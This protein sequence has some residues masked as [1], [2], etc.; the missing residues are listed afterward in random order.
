MRI[1]SAVCLSCC[2]GGAAVAGELTDQSAPA[3][4]PR[5]VR[6]EE[7]WRLGG[8]SDGVMF[9]LMIE[10]LSDADGNVYLLD[11][12]LNQVTVVA[13]DG[14]VRGTLFR[15]GDGPGEVRTPQDMMFLPDGSLAAA[16]QF[17]GKL[18]A[19][20]AD[21]TPAATVTL[22]RADAGGY[23]VMAS[24]QSR[25]GVMLVGA[26][27]QAPVD[28]GQSRLSYLATIG[29]DGAERVRYCEHLTI[30]DFEKAHFVEREMLA[31]FLGAHGLAP[32]GRVYAVPDRNAY[33]IDVYAPDGTARGSF[34]RAFAPQ[35]RTQRELDRMN[36]LFAVQDRNL[37][38]RITWE[39]ER[40]EAAISGLRVASDG[41]VWVEHARSGLAQPAG[42]FKTYDVF[43]ADGAWLREVRVA[44]DGD[45]AYDD[46]IFL[47]D[48]RVLLV[49]GLVLAR[50]T[51]SG[52]QGA[53]F[54]EAGGEGE[55]EVICCRAVPVP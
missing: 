16:Q 20:H 4:P 47:D 30:L 10:A 28:H 52:S 5:T 9:G 36:E 17:P 46:L 7:Q 25:G 22:G 39:V 13:P 37:P 31:P 18:I 11:Q 23:T 45:P 12:Q 27:Y 8:G 34:G 38:F 21:G 15:E 3:Q 19:V 14:S 50:L 35:P 24:C 42:V 49:K 43:S 26:L 32:D 29:P 55:L 54:D 33:R 53:V 44:V 40:N 41:E 51:A 48:G 2:L 1:L 6:L